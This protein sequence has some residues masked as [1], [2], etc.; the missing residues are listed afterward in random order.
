[1]REGLVPMAGVSLKWD[2]TEISRKKKKTEKEKLGG[3]CVYV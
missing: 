3:V 1:M 2:E